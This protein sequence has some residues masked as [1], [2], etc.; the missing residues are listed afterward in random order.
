MRLNSQSE[1]TWTSGQWKQW[2]QNI[3]WNDSWNQCH[4]HGSSTAMFVTGVRFAPTIYTTQSS[5]FD[6]GPV[7]LTTAEAK[8]CKNANP[9]SRL[10]PCCSWRL[11]P[12]YAIRRIARIAVAGAALHLLD[13]RAL[14]RRPSR[15]NNS[16]G[17]G[18]PLSL[19]MIRRWIVIICHQYISGEA[20]LL[21][22]TEPLDTMT[23]LTSPWWTLRSYLWLFD[24]KSTSEVHLW[25][26]A[27]I[28][29]ACN[30][31]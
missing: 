26:Y 11:G 19:N 13:G 28:P 31:T 3:F 21:F 29:I 23:P 15:R 10:F 1:K 5:L 9:L 2:W 12:F 16:T 24:R 30:L 8:T 18:C 6:L 14:K 22:I 25:C 27:T 4:T 17:N 20:I 7:S